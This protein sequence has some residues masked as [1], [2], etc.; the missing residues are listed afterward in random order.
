MSGQDALK[1]ILVT[2][3]SGSG[4]SIAIRALED[5]QFYCVDN[6]PTPFIPKVVNHL[7]LAGVSNMAIAVDSRSGRDL[8]DLP[9]LITQ[10]KEE[11]YDVR[12]LFLEADDDTLS[13]RY[14]ETRRRHPFSVK[15]GEK[16]TVAECV[17]AE[18]ET[19]Q[20]LRGFADVIDTTALLP[21]TLRR[22]VLEAVEERPSRLT[23][24]FETFGYKKGL[25][26]DADLVFD[27][28]CLSNPHYVK[29]LRDKTGI[30]YEVQAFI[31]EDE[32]SNELLS[33]IEKYLR[34]WL[35]SYLNEQRSYVTIAIGCTGGQHRSVYIAEMLAERFSLFPI[36]EV[37]SVLVRHRNI[38]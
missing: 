32:R 35:P 3:L 29:E 10:L 25:P 18:R 7:H 28:R 36:D 33:D 16:A 26:M 6:L 22:W 14:S 23:L 2:G 5:A 12:V 31:R 8:I 4:K 20:G 19:M 15:R 1:I 17:A 21:N 27:V 24:I 13:T 38:H 34:K 9:S 37:E 30:D 11:G